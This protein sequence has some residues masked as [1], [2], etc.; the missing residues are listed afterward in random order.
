MGLANTTK[1][2]IIGII[3][4]LFYK[5]LGYLIIISLILNGLY[6][7]FKSKNLKTIDKVIY[8]LMAVFVI[9]VTIPT[10]F[11]P[12]SYN[13]EQLIRDNW[14]IYAIAV[15]ITILLIGIYSYRMKKYYIE[16]DFQKKPLK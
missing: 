11:L 12:D 15:G 10:G 1:I 14:V 16:V 3:V 5:P 9:G 7:A 13:G 6:C 8:L 4:W 2:L